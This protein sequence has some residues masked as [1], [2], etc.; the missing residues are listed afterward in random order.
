MAAPAVTIDGAVELI[1]ARCRAT[2]PARATA[3]GL[4]GIDGSGKG[5]VGAEITRGLEAGGT[6]VALIGIDGWLHLPHDRFSAERPAEHFYHHAL[7][8]DAMF[9]QLVEPLRAARSIRLVAPYA[10]ET[11]IQY[12]EHVYEFHDVDVVLVEGI[13]LFKRALRAAF[14]LRLWIDCSFETAL[15]RAL[16]RAQEGL[17]PAETIRA[18]RT[19][20]F[21]AQR[22]HFER[23]H[24]RAAANAIISNDPARTDRWPAGVENPLL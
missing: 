21:P 24:P 4:S 7:R 22:I 2:P 15:E 16:A 14:D 5:Y 18:Y 20:Y 17:P 9:A 12:R 6:R 1:L 13:F 10:E 8:F 11:A 23:D 3:V 19:I